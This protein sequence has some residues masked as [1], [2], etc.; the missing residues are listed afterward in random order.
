MKRNHRQYDST[1]SLSDIIFK[2]L[3]VVWILYILAALTAAVEQ[4]SK[5]NVEHKAEFIITAQWPLVPDC[6][7]DMWI[8]DP[9]GGIIWFRNRE[10]GIIHLERDDLGSRNDTHSDAS[11]NQITNDENKEYVFFRGIKPGEYTFNLHL[12][13][14]VKPDNR[15]AFYKS[16]DDIGPIVVR[17]EFT[18]L[19]PSLQIIRTEE[20]SLRKIF[21]EKTVFNFTLDDAGKVVSITNIPVQMTPSAVRLSE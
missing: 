6:D 1:I 16:G 14:C 11:G 3:F 18:K 7:V 20:I 2:I 10:S 8:K 5:P 13:S 19:N 4:K 15:N 9:D 17:V 21:Q 12:Y